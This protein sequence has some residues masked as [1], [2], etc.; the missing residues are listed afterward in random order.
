MVRTA[1]KM[2]YR[3]I[4]QGYVEVYAWNGGRSM[5]TVNVGCVSQHSISRSAS[6]STVLLVFYQLHMRMKSYAR[7]S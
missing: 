5:V 6:S 1:E 3:V 4:C 2:I 7:R